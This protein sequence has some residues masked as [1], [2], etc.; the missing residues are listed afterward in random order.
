MR[1]RP[2]VVGVAGGSGS[3]KTTVVEQIIQALGGAEVTVL[4]QDAYYRDRS[5]LTLAQRQQINYD[6]PDAL[7][8]ELL[9]ANLEALLRREPIATPVYD[10]SQHARLRQTEQIEPASIVIVEGILVF[11]DPRLRALM[12]LRVFVETD[13][14][15]RFIRRL[16]RDLEERGRTLDSVV[17]QYLDTVRPMYLEFVEP[18]KRYADVI[19]PEGGYNS[20]AIDLVVSK[21]RALLAQGE[22][23]PS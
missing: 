16:K 21:L 1:A 6:H 15:V 17:A 14:D 2:F 19:I 9:I 5:E 11:Q 12:D 18:S 20:I 22:A 10:F 13:A 4:H 8:N 23:A 3:G 7:E